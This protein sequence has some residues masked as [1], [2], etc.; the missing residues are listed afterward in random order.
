[1]YKSYYANTYMMRFAWHRLEYLGDI[2]IIPS[3]MRILS[4]VWKKRNKQNSS[5]WINYLSS[6]T[7]RTYLSIFYCIHSNL[8][9]H[10]LWWIISACSPAYCRISCKLQDSD[11]LPAY[12]I[13]YLLLF[14]ACPLKYLMLEVVH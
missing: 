1:M 5:K 2:L 3:C 10:I 11:S 9:F 14:I 7:Y 13:T 4:E 6:K 12:L 8:K